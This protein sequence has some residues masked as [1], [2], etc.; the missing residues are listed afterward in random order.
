MPGENYYRLCDE[1]TSL[2]VWLIG[3][4]YCN[5]RAGSLFCPAAHT[6]IRM[7]N[8]NVPASWRGLHLHDHEWLVTSTNFLAYDGDHVIDLEEYLHRGNDGICT[9]EFTDLDDMIESV[10]RMIKGRIKWRESL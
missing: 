10:A 4:E 3:R 9:G 2:L 5:G 6:Q 7:I 8:P 1:Y